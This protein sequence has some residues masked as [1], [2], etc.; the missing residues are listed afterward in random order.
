VFGD[1]ST[2]LLLV[3][4][5][6]IVLG[7]VAGFVLWLTVSPIPADAQGVGFFGTSATGSRT[8]CDAIT[9]PVSGQ[10]WCTEAATGQIRVYFN[11]SWATVSVNNQQP[12]AYTIGGQANRVNDYFNYS[13]TA[14]GTNQHVGMFLDMTATNTLTAGF[15]RIPLGLRCVTGTVATPDGCIPLNVIAHQSSTAAAFVNGIEVSFNNELRNDLLNPTDFNHFGMT[16]DAYG[17]FTTGPAAL[18]IR[19]A[20]ANSQWARGIWITASTISANGYAFD[21]EGNGT[22]GPVRI[23]NEGALMV[24]SGVSFNATP[25]LVNSGPASAPYCIHGCGTS[26]TVVGTP[27]SMKVTMGSTGVPANPFTV[28]FGKTFTVA[29]S[30]I[31]QLNT[32]TASTVSVTNV[33]TTGASVNTHISPAQGSV[34]SIHCLGVG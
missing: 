6:G 17:G 20:A 8:N 33:T 7:F 23:T 5:L 26:P 21:Y 30:C 16:L 32:S 11:G 13:A 14:T 3:L 31:A 24:A 10:T 29:P 2:R 25:V 22:N 1:R 18:G 19:T 12:I 34:F 9:S 4:T 15:F 27:A 28:N